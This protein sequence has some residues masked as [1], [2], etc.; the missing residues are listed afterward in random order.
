MR[1]KTWAPIATFV[2]V[3]AVGGT[4]ALLQSG[5]SPHGPR[6]LRLSAAA[7]SAAAGNSDYQLDITLSDATPADMRAYTLTAGPADKDLVTRLARALTPS[8]L[9]VSDKAGQSW[10]WSECAASDTP[11]SSDGSSATVCA[12]GSGTA[13]A[14]PPPGVPSSPQPEPAVISRDVVKDGAREVLHAVGLDV[15]KATIDT[16]PYGGSATLD[17]RAVGLSTRVDVDRQGRITSASGWL[18]TELPGDSYPLISAKAAFDELPML[19]RPEVCQIAPDGK[20]CLPPAP[21]EIVGAEL[22][23]SVQPTADGGVVLV[24]SWLFALK[25]GGYVTAVAVEK[26]YRAGPTPSFTENPP[27]GAPTQGEPAPAQQQVAVMGARRGRSATAPSW[28]PA[29]A[30]PSR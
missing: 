13:V 20:G 2:A 12:S 30:R 19:A 3:A 21:T 28:T 10:S 18:G 16:S 6:V 8:G 9:V 5:G 1:A 11:V 23:L 17:G 15:D 4:A 14:V 7:L 24:P 26:Q 27:P 22:G 29:P 25:G